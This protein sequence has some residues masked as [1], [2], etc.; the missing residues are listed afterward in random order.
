MKNRR[1]NKKQVVYALTF[2]F[3]VL[4]TIV[5]PSCKKNDEGGNNNQIVGTW[6]CSN[7]WYGG[8]DTYVFRSNGKFQWNGPYDKAEY[9][10][11]SFNGVILTTSSASGVMRVFTILSL[12][13]TYFV[14]MD[15]DGDSYKYY[16]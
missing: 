15:Q 10:D 12:T 4:S 7:H 13:N 8:S 16:K 5:L 3:I 9:G 2:M 1:N 14:M 6:T 11:Y